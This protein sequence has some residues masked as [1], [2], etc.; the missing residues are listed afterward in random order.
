[1]RFEVSAR[2]D[3]GRRRGANEDFF[4]LD[5]K[6]GLFVVADGLGGHVAGRRAS[7]LGVGVFVGAVG[8]DPD[9][10]AAEVL[11]RAFARANEVILEAA[12]GDEKLRGMGTTLAA[13]WLRGDEA[14]V[15]HAGDSR[16]YLLRA[17]RLHMLTADHS[18]VAERVARGELTPEQARLHPSR[19]VI[20][21]A[22]GV[23]PFV[24][25]DIAALRVRAGDVFALCSDGISSQIPD[26]DI[27]RCLESG[28]FDLSRAASELVDIANAR[29][30]EDN[31]T[32]IVVALLD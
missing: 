24:E 13:L 26:A 22:V 16:L 25:P 17:G 32:V 18:L 4:A 28:R 9:G 12:D 2:S 15:A 21:R 11:R 31:A 19:H 30:G 3:T 27:E 6:L 23:Q 1:M 8:G 10:C 20:T 7:E 29:G 14:V 5:E